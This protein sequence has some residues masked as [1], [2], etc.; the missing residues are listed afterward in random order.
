ML[1]YHYS[2]L[3]S[4]AFLLLFSPWGYTDRM[5]FFVL[6]GCKCREDPP[7][8]YKTSKTLS[9]ITAPKDRMM[10]RSSSTPQTGAVKDGAGSWKQL[11]SSSC[12]SLLHLRLQLFALARKSHPENRETLM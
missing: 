8:R 11:E 5:P 10:L 6:S 2:L 4:I 3:F 12:F 9:G 1:I 7:S